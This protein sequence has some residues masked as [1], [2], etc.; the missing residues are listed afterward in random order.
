MFMDLIDD[1]V[2]RNHGERMIVANLWSYWAHLSIYRFAVPFAVG[3]RVLDAG[4]GAGYGAAY[5]SRH[6]AAGVLAFDAGVHAIEYSRQR[7]AGDAV[8]FEVADLNKPLPLGDRTFGLVFSS[9]VFDHV[10]NVDGL[11]AECARV[12][13]EDGVVI[14]AVPPIPTA[15]VMVSDVG[16]PF[17]VHH[18]PPVA[19]HA[20]L[21]RFFQDVRCYAHRH[22]GE[23]ASKEREQEQVAASMETCRIRETD[24]IFPE[25][26][27][28][29]LQ[30]TITAIFVCRAPR[31][32]PGPETLIER[33]PAIWREGEAAAR[34]LRAQKFTVSDLQHVLESTRN[35][36]DMA[37]REIERLSIAAREQAAAAG[38]DL[39]LA[40]RRAES[41]EALSADLSSRIAAIE[42]STCWRATAPIRA[43]VR[44]IRR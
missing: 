36:L 13:A 5:L 17:H 15:D 25:D 3:E 20:K 35:D 39:S 29:S 16:N 37:R 28:S 42:N 27:S 11:A 22:G 14:V 19:W 12:V 18:I 9:N 23:F 21:N 32:E 4:S 24:F 8:S 34:A 6:G 41:A 33:A 31:A 10:G 2:V 30:D 38:Q 7:Y 44:A 1:T 26:D 40:L 43:F